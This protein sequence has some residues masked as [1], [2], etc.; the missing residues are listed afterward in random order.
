VQQGWQP[1]EHGR[2]S[3]SER[4]RLICPCPCEDG[5]YITNA[6]GEA[7]YWGLDD[8]LHTY[9]YLVVYTLVV[10]VCVVFFFLNLEDE[11]SIYNLYV[12]EEP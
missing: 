4:H 2:S 1:W 5:K 9:N 11:M 10:W 8:I 3:P 7:R 12:H 6:L